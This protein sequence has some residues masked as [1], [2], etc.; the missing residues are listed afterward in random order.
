MTVIPI[1]SADRTCGECTLCCEGWLVNSAHGHNMWPGRKC[2]Y[3]SLHK[4]CTIYDQ[5][6]D[7]C[8]SYSCQWLIDKNIPEWM[9]PNESGVI[10]VFKELD[11]VS[12]LEATEA[13][14]KIDSEVLSWLFSAVTKKIVQNLK[15]QVNG[16]WNYFGTKEFFEIMT[17]HFST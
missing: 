13:G 8:R 2:Q 9:K 12:Y 11:G 4:G 14:K 5:R 6:P 17:K 10:L 15:Y 16:G 1:V 3:I 7:T